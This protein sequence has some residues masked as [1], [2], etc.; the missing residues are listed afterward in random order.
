MRLYV[1]AHTDKARAYD[2]YAAHY[3]QTD[4]QIYW[5]DDHQ[6][7]PYLPEAGEMLAGRLGWRHSHP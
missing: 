3:L 7:S 5:S 6:F 4:G 2:E 1:L